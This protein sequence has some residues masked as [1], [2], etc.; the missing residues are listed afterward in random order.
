MF[1]DIPWNIWGHSPECLVI[2]PGTWHSPHFPRSP[3]SVPRSCIPD[4]IHSQILIR[5]FILC[6]KKKDSL[7]STFEIYENVYIFVFISSF[8][9]CFC[10][11][12]L[13]VVRNQAPH[14]K[15]YPLELIKRASKIHKNS[16]RSKLALSFY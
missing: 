10:I 5:N 15:K 11:K 2:L 9:L 16:I 1:D 7:T 13:D 14:T 8:G 4:F 6:I 12:F 3:H